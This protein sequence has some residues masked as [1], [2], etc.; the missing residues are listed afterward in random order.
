MIYSLTVF[1][2]KRKA[3]RTLHLAIR[4]TWLFAALD[5]LQ[6]P[7]CHCADETAKRGRGRPRTASGPRVNVYLVSNQAARELRNDLESI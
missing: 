1:Q 7:S 3:V 4:N 2:A 5:G 6:P